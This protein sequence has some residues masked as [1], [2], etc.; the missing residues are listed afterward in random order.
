[1]LIKVFFI[2]L[3]FLA[4]F[5]P[6]MCES[7]WCDWNRFIDVFGRWVGNQRIVVDDDENIL[8]YASSKGGVILSKDQFRDAYQKWPHYRD[9]IKN[10]LIQFNFIADDII[11][12]GHPLGERG[13]R[14]EKIW[15]F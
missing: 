13:P 12:S 6:E 14:I 9:V 5:P 1:M 15:T 10:R 2:L 3:A 7:L 11:F 4:F 8:D